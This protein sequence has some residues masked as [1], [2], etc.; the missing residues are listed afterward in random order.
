MAPEIF[1]SLNQVQ[2]SQRLLDERVTDMGVLLGAVELK[3]MTLESFQNC[4]DA[5]HHVSGAIKTES[6]VFKTCLDDCEDRS[7]LEM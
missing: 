6:G 7:Q 2:A 4:S 1:S 3:V 5:F